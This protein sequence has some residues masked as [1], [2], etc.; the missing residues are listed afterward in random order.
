M[1]KK[2][3]KANNREL[4]LI[5]L[6][7][8]KHLFMIL[9][10]ILK[11]AGFAS[12]LGQGDMR[13]SQN[14][15]FFTTY[16]LKRQQTY[17]NKTLAILKFGISFLKSRCSRV[18]NLRITHSHVNPCSNFTCQ[19]LDWNPQDKRK[20]Y[21]PRQTWRRSTEAEIRRSRETLTQLNPLPSRTPMSA[22]RTLYE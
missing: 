20:V 2:K 4:F 18:Q 21:R 7:N 1:Q 3:K 5:F 15:Y 22:Q 9:H 12:N 13:D 6:V 16:L 10:W 19:A 17:F 14:V 11:Q 8:L